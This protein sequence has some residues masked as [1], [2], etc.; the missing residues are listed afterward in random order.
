MVRSMEDEDGDRVGRIWF[1]DDM[2]Y[3]VKGDWVGWEEMSRKW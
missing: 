1:R 3:G 2:G